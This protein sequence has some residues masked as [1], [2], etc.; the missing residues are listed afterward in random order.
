MYTSISSI[1]CK[2]QSITF[3]YFL[4]VPLE[5]LV[6]YYYYYYYHHLYLHHFLMYSAPNQR[7][8][9]LTSCECSRKLKFLLIPCL[10]SVSSGCGSLEESVSV[11]LDASSSPSPSPREVKVTPT[12]F[13]VFPSASQPYCPVPFHERH[14]TVVSI[15]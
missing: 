3:F 11:P 1:T 14:W 9:S 15:F 12:V 7:P 10:A 8:F 6:W 2:G 5:H 13:E 4:L